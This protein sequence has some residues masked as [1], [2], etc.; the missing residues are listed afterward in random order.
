M[1]KLFGIVALTAVISA[2]PF[3]Q[4]ANAAPAHRS[5]TTGQEFACTY[6]GYPC[7]DWSRIQD[8]W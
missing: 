7:S 6:D 8:G 4:A 2:Q 1:K 5:H 3:V